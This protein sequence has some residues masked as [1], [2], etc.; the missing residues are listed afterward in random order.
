MAGLGEPDGCSN[1]L[2]EW[3]DSWTRVPTLGF[4]RSEERF[5]YKQGMLY[6]WFH[7]QALVHKTGNEATSILAPG[8]CMLRS[9]LLS[10]TPT[11]EKALCSKVTSPLT[12]I[13][14]SWFPWLQALL[15]DKH[16]PPTTGQEAHWL[17]LSTKDHGRLAALKTHFSKSGSHFSFY[18]ALH[19]IHH[20][21]R[22]H[23]SL[24]SHCD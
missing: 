10:H 13:S 6:Y 2:A 7:S 8:H 16:I 18:L 9:S 12:T 5:L 3:Q 4:P 15:A 21:S 11:L 14:T 17:E 19:F 20:T 23:S 1:P 22:D 24:S